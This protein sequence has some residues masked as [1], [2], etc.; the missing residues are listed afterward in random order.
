MTQARTLSATLLILLSLLS[1]PGM[2]STEP[3]QDPV[4][5]EEHDQEIIAMMDLL[6][7]MDL[8]ET[9]DLLV[10]IEDSKGD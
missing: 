8:L 10:V 7:I 3:E 6:E 2:A 9:M 4:K 1:F 5:L